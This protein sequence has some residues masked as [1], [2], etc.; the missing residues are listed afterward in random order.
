[1]GVILPGLRQAGNI[2]PCWGRGAVGAPEPHGLASCSHPAPTPAL[3]CYS[4]SDKAHFSVFESL[5]AV[6]NLPAHAGD[7]GS[8]PRSG[9]SPEEGNGNPLQYCCLRNLMD[10]GAWQATIHGFTTKHLNNNRKKNFLFFSFSMNTHPE[11]LLTGVG[12]GWGRGPSPWSSC[13]DS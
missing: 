12:R 2:L 10:R 7:A 1:M 13:G 3:V 6:Q 5:M 11:A 8:I 9:R 4:H